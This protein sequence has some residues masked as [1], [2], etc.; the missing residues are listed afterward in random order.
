VRKKTAAALKMARE[1]LCFDDG[2]YDKALFS[3]D[4][5]FDA[6]DD[7]DSEGSGPEQLG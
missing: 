1:D 7:G 2:E 6:N 5:D 4:H 3:V